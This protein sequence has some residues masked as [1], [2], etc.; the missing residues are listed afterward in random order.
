MQR[1]QPNLRS[2][3]S[4]STCA[5]E[6]QKTF[7]PSGSSKGRSSSLQLFSS[8]RSRSQSVSSGVPL[9]RR[10]ITVRSN[11]LLLMFRAMSAGL[12]TH[13][14]PSMILPSPSEMLMF[15][16][17]SVACQ[18]EQQLRIPIEGHTAG[19]LGDLFVVLRLELLAERCQLVG[20]DTRIVAYKICIRW[21][22]YAGAGSSIKGRPSPASPPLAFFSF[23]GFG[24]F[25]S[26]ETARFLTPSTAWLT[27]SLTASAMVAVGCRV[28]SGMRQ[29]I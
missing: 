7:L 25:C 26:A 15:S 24:A 1:S 11:K 19:L 14:C 17:K 3:A 16:V 9:S 12:V 10:A 23:L 13:D 29:S 8:G 28:K 18:W 2:E 4:P 21:S 20:H 22:I 27:A 6:C 5:L